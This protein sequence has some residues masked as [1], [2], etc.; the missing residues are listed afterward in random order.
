MR[1][2]RGE[3]N[4]QRRAD[5]ATHGTIEAELRSYCPAPRLLEARDRRLQI[6]TLEGGQRFV[7]SEHGTLHCE[8]QAVAGH[9]ID[10]TRSIA[11][12][13]QTRH[14]DRPRVHCQ[15]AHDTDGMS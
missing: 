14:A 11:G 1:S 5:D 8:T 2:G 13:E 12:K 3:V 10:E 4:G 6:A 9:R 7:R 15:W